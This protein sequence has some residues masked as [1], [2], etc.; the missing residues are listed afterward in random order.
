MP[1]SVDPE[2]MKAAA[3]LLTGN[4]AADRDIIK[5]YEA[6]AV[7]LKSQSFS[8]QGSNAGFAAA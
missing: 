3:P 5:F 8:S 4:P 2:V 1:L 7:V 6:R